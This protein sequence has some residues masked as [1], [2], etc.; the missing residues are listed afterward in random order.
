MHTRLTPLIRFR[1]NARE[2]M[3]FYHSVFG[4]VLEIDTYG[5]H[6]PIDNPSG[7]VMHAR[8]TTPGGLVI[9]AADAPADAPL[10]RGDDFSI[11]LGGDNAEELR[12]FFTGLVEGGDV[13]HPLA[14]AQWGDEFGMLRDRFGVSWLVNITTSTSA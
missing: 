10:T 9:M 6:T 5:D 8:L 7:S 13:L 11:S 1:D 2:A 12:S 3:T 14:T 4:G